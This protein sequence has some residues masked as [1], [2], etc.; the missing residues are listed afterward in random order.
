MDHCRLLLH[1]GD[2]IRPLL[3]IAPRWIRETIEDFKTLRKISAL[4]RHKVLQR[5]SV[6]IGGLWFHFWSELES[7]G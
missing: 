6:R 4:A 3:D 5:L 7:T 2:D 1:M